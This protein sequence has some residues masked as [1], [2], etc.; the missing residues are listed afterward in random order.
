MKVAIRADA[1]KLQGSGHVMRCLS[2]ARA[3]SAKNVDVTFYKS[4][5]ELDWL[6][7]SVLSSGINIEAT[8]PNSLFCSSIIWEDFDLIVVDSY[9]IPAKEISKLNTI[10][11]VLVIIDGDRRGIEADIYLDQNLGSEYSIEGTFEQGAQQLLLF[12]SKYSLVRP[13]V[14]ENRRSDIRLS[15]TLESAKLL[16][17]FGGSDPFRGATSLSRVLSNSNINNFTVIAPKSDHLEIAQYLDKCNAN[18]IEFTDSIP[19]LIAE[20]DAVVSAAGTSAWDISTIGTPAGYFGVAD[21]Q[22]ASLEAIERY[23][24]GVSLGELGKIDENSAIVR[25]KIEQLILDDKKRVSLFSSSHQLFDG[26]GCHRVSKCTIRKILDLNASE[27]SSG[28]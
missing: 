18:I 3:L 11:P 6:V 27:N 23:G 15:L 12:G 14:L 24:V 2:L 21:N 17:F 4:I 7:T 9:Q 19:R 20:A 25:Q 5:R 10:R 28:R 22:T 8:I 1:S 13:E 16:V 26:D